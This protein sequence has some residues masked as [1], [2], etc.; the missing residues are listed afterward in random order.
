MGVEIET[1]QIVGWVLSEKDIPEKLRKTLPEKSHMEDRFDEKTGKKLKPE[2]VLDEEE[3]E[4]FL[5]P[6]N[7]MENTEWQTDDLETFFDALATDLKMHFVIA[8]DGIGG[9]YLYCLTMKTTKKQ[10]KDGIPIEVVI[11]SWGKLNA[12]KKKLKTLG[13]KVGPAKIQYAELYS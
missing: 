5:L 13:F 4:V 10:D 6:G 11:K 12:A 2:K 1:Y 9:E 8:G 7:K 3:H